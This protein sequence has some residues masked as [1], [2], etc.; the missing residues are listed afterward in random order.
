MLE[1]L[2]KFQIVD[3]VGDNVGKNVM[4]V[5]LYIFIHSI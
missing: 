3:K 2:K 5:E 1:T 4:K